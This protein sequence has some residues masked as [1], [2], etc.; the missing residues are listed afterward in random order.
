LKFDNA[1]APYTDGSTDSLEILTSTNGGTSYSSLV[2][3]WGNNVN[4][5]LNTAA[6]IGTAFTPTA[7]QWATKKY[8]LPVG[9][10]KVKFR[11]RAGFGNNLYLDSICKISPAPVTLL[12]EGFT[13]ATF[14]PASWNI[15]FTGT[16]Y[17]TRETVSSYGI[18]TGSAKFDYFNAATGTTQSLVTL[19]FSNSAAG[20]LLKFDNAYAPYTDGSTDT[21]EIL[22]SSNGGTSYSTLTR[23]WGNNVNGNLN[24]AA[25]IGTAFL[26]TAGQ[27]ATRSF[28]LPTGTNKIKF[29][30]RSGFG[31][32]LYLDS[33]CKVSSSAPV[34]A[35]ITLA[36]Q[37][38]YEPVTNKLN[39]RDTVTFY[40]RN[41]STP[42]AIVDSGKAVIDSIS[43]SGSVTFANAASGTYFLVV[44]SR[45]ILETWSKSGGQSYTRGAAFSYNFTTS[46]AQAYGSNMILEGAKYC[47][48]SGDVSKNNA[49]D[50]AD[51]LM[52]YNAATSFT[53]GFN[54]L[55]LTGDRTVDLT[56]VLIAF[57]NSTNFVSRQVPPGAVIISEDNQILLKRK[58]NE[59]S[60]SPIL[61][62]KVTG[63]LNNEVIKKQIR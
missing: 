47:I 38:Y 39:I 44:K 5:N 3:L 37:G 21:L 24:T 48:Y 4:G 50:L 51:V 18:G 41:I 56:D 40:L 55:D 15:E 14:A 13:G 35:T 33:I 1:Y 61:M 49:V 12:C 10:N 26:P 42:F 19:T 30:A 8:S 53:S 54:A 57:N 45:N 58:I 59:I 6:P 23:L 36:P 28:A 63:D 7:G 11:S 32:N 62:E 46:A 60:E 22:S 31:N 9:T 29:R 43:L 25:P 17:W 34:P 2:R 16:N 20:D 27:W 52:V